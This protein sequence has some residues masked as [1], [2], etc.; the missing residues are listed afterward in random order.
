M[1]ICNTLFGIT[2]NVFELQKTT[3]MC[4]K[5]KNLSFQVQ[6][7]YA[8]Q[9]EQIPFS[10][11]YHIV[12][13]MMF[14]FQIGLNSSNYLWIVTQSVV[15]NINDKMAGRDQSWSPDFRGISFAMENFKDP[16]K[17]DRMFCGYFVG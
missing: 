11:K 5:A 9:L 14:C 13:T 2:K 7:N 3:T 15:G 6:Y 12:L 8:L 17:T 10:C 16:S 4:L 1:H